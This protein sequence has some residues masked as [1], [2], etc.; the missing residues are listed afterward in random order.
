MSV[1]HKILSVNLARHLSDHWKWAFHASSACAWVLLL[2]APVVGKW[3]AI[4]KWEMGEKQRSSSQPCHCA[5]AARQ[6]CSGPFVA[7]SRKD[8]EGVP[9]EGASVHEE[10][11]LLSQKQHVGLA[12]LCFPAQV[13]ILWKKPSCCVKFVHECSVEHL[14]PLNHESIEGC[15]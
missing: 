13:C 5:T 8:W 10:M 14:Q 2:G 3:E 12:S 15:L 7:P 6:G 1:Q 11:E 9:V 4:V